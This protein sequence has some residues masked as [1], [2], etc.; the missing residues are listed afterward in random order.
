[1]TL[2]KRAINLPAL[3]QPPVPSTAAPNPVL[4]EKDFQKCPSSCAQNKEQR[5]KTTNF[6]TLLRTG[7]LA[8]ASEGCKFSATPRDSCQHVEHALVGKHSQE[9]VTRREDSA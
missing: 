2:H 9:H 7:R 8:N 5:G 4:E 3:R 6:G 1:V